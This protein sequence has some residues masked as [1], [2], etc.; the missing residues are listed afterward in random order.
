VLVGGVALA[1]G[2]LLDALCLE[3]SWPVI[4]KE[5]QPYHIH[6]FLTLAPAIAVDAVTIPKR[7]TARKPFV[8][9][10]PLRRRLRTGNL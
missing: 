4:A 5:I 3:N 1:V 2:A 8:P 6:L 7:T 9:F 10:P